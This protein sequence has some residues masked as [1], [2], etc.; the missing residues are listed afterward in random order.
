[1]K[2]S[3][4]GITGY[5]GLELVRILNGH[6]KVEL[7]SVH[8]TKEIG[9]KLSD[10]YSYLKGIC[11]LE[12]QSFDSQKIMATADLVFFATP[13]GVAKELAKDFIAADFPVIDI[14][15]DHR[16]PAVIYEKWY[17]KAAAEQASLDKFT[18]ALAELTDV[19]GK[20]FI[21]NPGCYAT[22][23]ELALLPLVKEKLIDV[24]S[25]IV[26]AKSGLTGAGKVLSESSHFVNVHDNYVTYKLNRHQHIPEIVQEL[27][28]FDN[29]LEHIQFS[30]S[31][32]PV[33]R[34]IMAT[35]YVTLKK[36][37]SNEAISKIYQDLYADKPFVRLQ[38]DLP[39]LHNVIGSNFCDIGFAYNPVTNVL[40][41][42]SVIDNLVKG[43][44]GQA[45]QNLNLMMGWDE[46]EGFPMT[47]SYL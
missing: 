9:T 21:A 12:I 8:A 19:K 5:S 27:K 33:N 24:N 37:L 44:A 38:Q 16:L 13:S 3:I 7:V 15:G 14:S 35:C 30:T 6:Q 22:A 20:K 41:V 1:M 23:T 43:A 11:D 29:N 2:V 39:E 10:I 34:G 28:R 32:L 47:P 36:P 42:I 31:L 25:I 26:D 18:Y 45:V 17:K 4:V 46:T 40:T